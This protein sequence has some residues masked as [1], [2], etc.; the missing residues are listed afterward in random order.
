MC[1]REGGAVGG[2]LEHAYSAPVRVLRVRPLVDDSTLGQAFPA[3]LP[4]ISEASK[5]IEAG[6]AAGAR[7][8]SA[9]SKPQAAT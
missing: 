5:S 1:R 9:A 4:D 3:D 6:H 8:I 7:R 2:G